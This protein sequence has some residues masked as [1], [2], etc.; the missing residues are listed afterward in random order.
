MFFLFVLVGAFVFLGAGCSTS[1]SLPPGGV[2]MSEDGGETWT[3]RIFVDE[4]KGK[5]RTIGDLSI[6]TLEIDPQNPNTFYIGTNVGVFKTIN[7]GNQ[8]TQT[9]LKTGF[10]AN[11]ALDPQSGGVAYVTSGSNIYKTGNGGE[12]WEIIYV[13]PQ[14]QIMRDIEVDPADSQKITAVNKGG[15]V[16]RSVDAGANWNIVSEFRT[17]LT[18]LVLHP[19][20]PNT[21]YAVTK[22]RG[23][24]VSRNGGQE[25]EE[26]AE[27]NPDVKHSGDIRS[28]V[29]DPGNAAVLYAGTS[30]GLFRSEDGGGT[31]NLIETL[32]PTGT[33]P[34]E[35]VAVNTENDRI[36]YFEVDNVIHKSIDRGIT[37]KTIETY[38]RARP[39]QWVQIH[40]TQSSEVYTGT[41]IPSK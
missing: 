7:R 40:P 35:H 33:K 17:E 12:T 29:I 37:W 24:R 25:W 1:P 28:F 16:I 23:Y 8:W 38:P 41:L 27:L 2:W 3:Q 10:V 11:I 21:L 18:Q 6:L 15:V 14:S 36:L 30:Q 4:V 5:V 34:I 39:I 20:Q 31:W 19:D 22:N 32:V 13:D 26:V 9:G